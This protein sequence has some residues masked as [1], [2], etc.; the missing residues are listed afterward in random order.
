MRGLRCAIAGI[1]LLGGLASQARAQTE[2]PAAEPDVGWSNS[3]AL[4][5]VVTQGNA[6]TSSL[7]FNNVLKRNWKISEFR[8]RVD[9]TRFD[10][11][12]DRYA[13]VQPGD[14]PPNPPPGFDLNDLPYEVIEPP[15]EVDVERYFIEGRY[16]KKISEK[17]YWNAGAS[18][19]RDIDAGIIHR[20][21]GF[22]GVG[23]VWWKRDDLNFRTDYGLSY[24]DREEETPDPEKDDRFAGAR[25][26]WDYDNMWGKLTKYDN[27]LTLNF[28][29][30]DPKDYMV[31][32]I[33]AVTV[34]MSKILSIRVSLQFLYNNEPALEDV[35]I[36]TLIPNPNP[37][38]GPPELEI[39]IGEVQIRRK[40]L[41]TTFNTS[42]VVSF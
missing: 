15:V 9:A 1:L 21:I 37:G 42:I 2:E 16:S 27:D 26:T 31:D 18:W 24:T 4:S 17:L 14:I 41:D 33:N 30:T 10:E 32:M 28:N 23:N 6:N 25:F 22:G 11:S 12:D 36:V 5:L 20:S 35:D 3:T 39:E 19:F 8:L 13:V 40:S 7:G 29:L 34:K 38:I